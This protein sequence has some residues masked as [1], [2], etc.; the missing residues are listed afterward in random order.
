M[1]DDHCSV[2]GK[3]AGGGVPGL[4]AVCVPFTNVCAPGMGLGLIGIYSALILEATVRAV[5]MFFRFRGG[6]WQTMKV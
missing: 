3:A 6:K 5:L 1:G 2:A 4:G